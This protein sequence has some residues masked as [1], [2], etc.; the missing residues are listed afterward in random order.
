MEKREVVKIKILKSAL[1]EAK[2]AEIA[3]EVSMRTEADLV[4]ARGHIF[5]LYKRRKK[6]LKSE[7]LY[8]G[9][10]ELLKEKR[11]KGICQH[12]TMPQRQNLSKN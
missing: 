12:Q 6:G 4:E 2:A 9:L 10:G 3:L 8:I 5:V 11:G 7:S 1:K